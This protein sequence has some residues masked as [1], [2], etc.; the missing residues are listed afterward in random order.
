MVMREVTLI[1]L[2]YAALK[3]HCHIFVLH[4]VHISSSQFTSF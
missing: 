2:L 3:V 4:S 1:P